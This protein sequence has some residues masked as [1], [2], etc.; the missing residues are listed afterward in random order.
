MNI[1]QKI[2]NELRI[3]MFRGYVRACV[4]KSV[5]EFRIEYYK[6][7]YEL[8]IGKYPDGTLREKIKTKFRGLLD[9]AKKGVDVPTVTFDETMEILT[10][11]AKELI[12]KE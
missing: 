10:D 5:A 11:K 2:I 1:R 9:F 7:L 4:D 6:D 3:G 8:L 12:E